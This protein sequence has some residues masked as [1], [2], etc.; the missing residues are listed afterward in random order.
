MNNLTKEQ[1]L[2]LREK[3]NSQRQEILQDNDKTLGDLKKFN[4]DEY[5]DPFDRA[6]VESENI[7]SLRIKDRS[8]K[9]LEKIDEALVRLDADVINVCEE[10]DEAIGFERL[11]ARPVT[12][13]CISCKERQEQEERSRTH[14]P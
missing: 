14:K 11:L 13:L 12:T 1:S 4:P 10:C 8:R 9:L 3:L 6:K 5:S 2:A 7:L